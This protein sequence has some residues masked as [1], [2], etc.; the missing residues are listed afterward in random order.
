MLV[1]KDVFARERKRVART[2]S[3]KL[4]FCNPTCVTDARSKFRRH[5]IS[6]RAEAAR[7]RSGAQ[8]AMN[9]AGLNSLPRR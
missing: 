5:V 3:L 8:A 6:S 9:A 7:R 2:N 4:R 1:N